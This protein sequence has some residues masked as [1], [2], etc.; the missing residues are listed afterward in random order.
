MIT[1]E[2]KEELVTYL[3]NRKLKVTEYVK[4][5]HLTSID[6]ESSNMKDIQKLMDD[7]S[8]SGYFEILPE[9][10]LHHYITTKLGEEF[11]NSLDN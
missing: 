8:E 3:I 7:Y 11:F 10:N 5:N 6:V 9:G 2:L 1:E 4:F